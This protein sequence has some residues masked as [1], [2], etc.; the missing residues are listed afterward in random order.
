[1]MTDLQ[2]IMPILIVTLTAIVTMVA[3]SF[4]PKNERVPLGG[5]G[6]IGLTGAAIAS[7]LLWGRDLTGFGVV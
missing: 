5:L 4:Q 2:A 1:M 7:V 6:L 3:E